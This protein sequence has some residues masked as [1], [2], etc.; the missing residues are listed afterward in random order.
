MS[1]PKNFLERW[2]RRKRETAGKPA[3]TPTEKPEDKKPD[4]RPPGVDARPATNEAEKPFEATTLP[5]IDS[6]TADT[7][8]S[9]FLQAGVP[10]DLKREALRRAWSADPGIRDFVGLSENS[11]DFNDPHAVTGFGPIEPGEVTRLM[12]QFIMTPPAEEKAPSEEV[13]VE[14]RIVSHAPASHS[15]ESS[16]GEPR[17]QTQTDAASQKESERPASGAGD[18]KAS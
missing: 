18:H 10:E 13:K 4:A 14:P 5:R 17:D 9:G 15:A 12:A 6:I 11:W 2:S 8:I 1:E 16:A 7:D 3:E